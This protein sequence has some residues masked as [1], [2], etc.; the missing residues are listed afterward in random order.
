MTFKRLH[1][2]IRSRTRDPNR[3]VRRAGY[4]ERRVV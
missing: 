3:A 1:A 4:Y 2:L